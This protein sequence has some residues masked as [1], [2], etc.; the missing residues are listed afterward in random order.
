MGECQEAEG[1][2]EVGD[3]KESDDEWRCSSDPEASEEPEHDAGAGVHPEL[4]HKGEDE[5]EAADETNS[6]PDEVERSAPGLVC[7]EAGG[8]SA[9][10]TANTNGR[11]KKGDHMVGYVG[12]GCHWLDVAVWHKQS[13]HGKEISHNQQEKHPDVFVTTELTS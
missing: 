7:D 11:D 2:V 10:H 13:H 12:P 9:S 3:T 6:G 8:H 4:V 5:W 1:F